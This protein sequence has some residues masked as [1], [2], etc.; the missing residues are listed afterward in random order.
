[1]VAGEGRPDAARLPHADR[2]A[3]SRAAALDSLGEPGPDRA[4]LA[5]VPWRPL[6]PDLTPRSGRPLSDRGRWASSCGR[7]GPSPPAGQPD[8]APT[9]ARACA[10]TRVLTRFRAG[11]ARADASVR[12]DTAPTPGPAHTAR[13]LRA[14]RSCAGSSRRARTSRR[15]TP[16]R[17]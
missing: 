14:A 2:A 4:T 9:A 16:R 7:A 6:V 13:H 8:P 15:E 11:G 3:V 1:P 12:T 5:A 10:S 17:Q